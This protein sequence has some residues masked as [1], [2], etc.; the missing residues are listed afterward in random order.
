MPRE[1]HR[2]LMRLLAE[3]CEPSLRV[4]RP[5]V[6]RAELRLERRYDHLDVGEAVMRHWFAGSGCEGVRGALLAL[7]N[8]VSSGPTEQET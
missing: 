6:V 7:E 5:H 8:R 3:V 1:P 2:G 4:L